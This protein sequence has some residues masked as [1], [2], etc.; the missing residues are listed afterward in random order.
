MV[1]TSLK[2]NQLVDAID[3]LS[4]FLLQ[5]QEPQPAFEFEVGWSSSYDQLLLENFDCGTSSSDE[6]IDRSLNTG[7][8]ILSGRAGSAKTT[9]IYRLAKKLLKEPNVFPVLINLKRWGAPDYEAWA[10]APE[11]NSFRLNVLLRK[12]H[13]STNL[14]VLEGVDQRILRVLLIDGLNEIRSDVAA[15]IIRVID[16]YI[17]RAAQSVAIMTDRVVRRSLDEPKRWQLCAVRPIS[18][19]EIRKQLLISSDKVAAF[20]LLRVEQK[21]MLGTP[22]FLDQFLKSEKMIGNVV[23]TQAELHYY[24]EKQIGLSESEMRAASEASFAMYNSPNPSRTFLIESF[25]E[26][27]GEA[28]TEKLKA[29]VLRISSNGLAYFY[30][31]LHHDYLAAHH[32]SQNKALWTQ[33][34]FDALT[35]KAASFDALAFALEEVGSQGESDSFLRA[36]YDWNVYAPAYALSEAKFGGA[37]GVSEDMEF[38]IYSMLAEKR[39]D[40]ILATAQKAT[41]ALSVFSP[42]SRARAFLGISSVEELLRYVSTAPALAEPYEDWRRLFTTPSDQ[43]VGEKEII[44]ITSAN[45]I[46]GWTLANVLKRTP[47]TD[48][49]QKMLRSWAKENSSNSSVLWRIVHVIGAFPSIENL[50]FLL[51]I[52][53]NTRIAWPRYGAVRSIIELAGKSSEPSL[54]ARAFEALM[55]RVDKLSQTD[56]L[57]ELQRAIFVRNAPSDWVLNVLPLL[58]AIAEKQTEEID[59][60]KWVR[61]AYQLRK[62][63][64][65]AGVVQVV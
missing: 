9:I 11:D 46:M 36:L 55:S 19:E 10:T 26:V 27:A 64:S 20:D 8:V 40:Y 60:D 4:Q 42:Q 47:S 23:T 43:M 37:T 6:I 18:I 31:H 62:H 39:W 5:W 17:R 49:R 16:V 38:V 14:A 48:Q 24:F 7:R 41:D 29:S 32:L 35:F 33:L 65:T 15:Q 25:T 59:R 51:G 57:S 34:G 12:A 63:Y 2:S 30:H 53:D 1:N 45:S 13:P 50:N 61:A 44:N 52:F 28:T 56:F 58:N 3:E 22:L 54:R 21:Q